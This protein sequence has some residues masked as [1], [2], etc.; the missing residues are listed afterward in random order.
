MPNYDG[1]GPRGKGAMTGRGLGYC[2]V[3]I[4]TA[5]EELEYLRK[6][7]E[8]LREE[9]EWV[10]DRIKKLEEPAGVAGKE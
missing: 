10:R 7:E 6:R 9:L 3:P 4:G 5:E 1:S 8:A 2:I